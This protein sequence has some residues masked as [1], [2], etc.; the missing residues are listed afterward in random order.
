MASPL[1]LRAGGLLAVGSAVFL[2][3]S[4]TFTAG[5]AGQ[6]FEV[7]G[8]VT[9]GGDRS[10]VQ[11][12]GEVGL[13]G[14][15]FGTRCPWPSVRLELVVGQTFGR[16]L[17]DGFAALAAGAVPSLEPVPPAPSPL[18]SPSVSA[19]IAPSEMVTASL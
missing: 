6:L 7:G 11:Q 8:L 15:G 17:D 19:R 16:L 10:G 1:L 12:R 18:A 14:I 3:G 4:N 9:L 5:I 2:T 13:L